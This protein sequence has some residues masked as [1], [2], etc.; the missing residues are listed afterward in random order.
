M[1]FFI[2][3]TLFKGFFNNIAINDQ[4]C[5]KYKIDLQEIFINVSFIM[6]HF[7]IM[8]KN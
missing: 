6:F 2:N 1:K 8:A 3:L 7:S 5:I 4:C